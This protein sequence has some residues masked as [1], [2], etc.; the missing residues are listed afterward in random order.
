MINEFFTRLEAQNY[1]IR[2]N[3]SNNTMCLGSCFAVNIGSKLEQFKVPTVVNPLGTMFHP[4]ALSSLL[5]PEFE[6]I[7]DDERLLLESD[8]NF[9]HYAVHSDFYAPSP[10]ELK[11]KIRLAY[12]NIKK[13]LS[14]TRCLI[15]TIGTAWVFEHKRTG[16]LVASCHKQPA[17]EFNRRL[18]SLDET[19]YSLRSIRKNIPNDCLLVVSLSPVRHTRNGLVADRDSKSLL[20]YALFK[21]SK[22]FDNTVYFPSYEIM[23]DELRD[24]RFFQKDLIHP[25]EQA[26]EIIWKRFVDELFDTKSKEFF[27]VW[28]KILEGLAHRPRN[29]Q[30]AAYLTHRIGLLKKMKEISQVDLSQEIKILKKD[31]QDT[32]DHLNR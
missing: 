22:E 2:L 17:Q 31:I 16:M 8:E 9:F 5:S 20:R 15:I 26:I 21:A 6:K 13:A 25:N 10:S 4:C 28:Q 29:R 19:L 14:D 1:P 27:A 30:S 23:L 3:H 11:N 24:Y 12:H 7:V 18:L 32:Q